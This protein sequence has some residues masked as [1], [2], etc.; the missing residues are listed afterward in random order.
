MTTSPAKAIVTKALSPR[1]MGR[2]AAGWIRS[3]E[4]EDI[5]PE[6]AALAIEY[7]SLAAV[8]LDMDPESVVV[9]F[10][11][12]CAESDPGAVARSRSHVHG[13][14][15]KGEAGAIWLSVGLSPSQLAETA[16]HEVRHLWQTRQGWPAFRSVPFLERDARDFGREWAQL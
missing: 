8:D 14:A 9:F 5:S 2:P 13:F 12:R 7:V 1:T 15:Q 10:F 11:T 6:Y 16:A 3:V 4:P